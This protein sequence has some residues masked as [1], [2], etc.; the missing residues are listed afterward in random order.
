ME[1]KEK[2]KEVQKLSKI[3]SVIQNLYY[4]KKEQL[5]ELQ[6]EISELKEVLN[7]LNSIVS[8]KSFHS[9]DEIYHK[10]LNIAGKDDIPIENY[11]QEEIPTETSKGTKIKRKIFSKDDQDLLCVLNFIDFNQIEIKFIDPES[12]NIR[13]ESEDF[14]NIFLKGA[15]IPI[16]E[17]HPELKLNYIEFKN[18]DIIEKIQITNITSIN[19]YDLITDKI[20]ELLLV[21]KSKN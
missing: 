2:E 8:N 17:N 10:A 7:H 5:D 13:E 3:L 19:D 21:I 12:R 18:S 16:K 11:F 14:I 20:R 15:L 6:Q 9:A 4:K 1:G